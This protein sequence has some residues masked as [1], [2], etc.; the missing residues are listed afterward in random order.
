MTLSTVQPDRSAS[1]DSERPING[2]VE[3]SRGPTKVCASLVRR[4]ES[5]DGCTGPTQRRAERDGKAALRAAGTRD[6]ERDLARR[7]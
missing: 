6:Q 1:S 3:A 5:D 7:A 4:D 2:R